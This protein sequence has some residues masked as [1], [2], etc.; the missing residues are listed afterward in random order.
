MEFFCLGLLI[1]TFA[2]LIYTVKD[3]TSQMKTL[4]HVHECLHLYVQCTFICTMY[5]YVAKCNK[6]VCRYAIVSASVV[7][8][9][10]EV[11]KIRIHY[12]AVF[13]HKHTC[14]CS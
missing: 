14:T 2:F 5:I 9:L 4:S 1:K 7:M 10:V 3:D 12:S 6:I 13:F 8:N 11:L